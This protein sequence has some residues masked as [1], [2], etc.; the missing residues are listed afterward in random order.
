MKARII[1]LDKNEHSCQMAKECY[2][3]AVLH[4]L[5]PSYFKAIDGNDAEL[6]YKSSSVFARRKM[7]KGRLGVIGCFFSHYYLWQECVQNNTPFVILEHD[8]YMLKPLPENILDTFEDVLKLDRCDPFSNNYNNTLA[9]ETDM[10][11]AVEKYTNLHNKN[12]IK[13]GTGN[14]FK[15]AYAYIIKPVGAKKIIDWISENGHV[16]ADQQIGDWI[17]NTQT[18][19]PSLARLHPFYAIGSN[20]KQASLTRN[21]NK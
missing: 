6:H 9:E 1:R 7:K 10:P 14:Y 20:I 18:T 21:L 2:D 11:F 5:S 4:G 16:P 15:G 3:Q 12:P 17:V 13:I 19:V 8:G